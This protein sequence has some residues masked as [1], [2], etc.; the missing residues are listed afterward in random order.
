MKPNFQ[1]MNRAELRVYLKE[2]RDDQ[3]AFEAYMDKLATV[4]ILAVHSLTTQESLTDVIAKVNA[5]RKKIKINK[6]NNVS[7]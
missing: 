1:A 2:Y 7:K 5:E 4:P 6:N 3:E